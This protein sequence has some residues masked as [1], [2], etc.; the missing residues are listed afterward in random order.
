M[1]ILT[2]ILSISFFIIIII[3]AIKYNNFRA[4][5]SI[6]QKELE[7]YKEEKNYL[8]EKLKEAIEQNNN[9]EVKLGRNKKKLKKIIGEKEN[10][11]SELNEGRDEIDR[12][13]I[14]NDKYENTVIDNEYL[15][16]DIDN[17]KGKIEHLQFILDLF[18]VKDLQ[19]NYEYN[20]EYEIKKS[21][22]DAFNKLEKIFDEKLSDF[23][24]EN[25]KKLDKIRNKI[26][27]YIKFPILYEKNSIAVIGGFSSGKSQF[28][29]S[30]TGSS[31]EMSIDMNVCTAIPTYISKNKEDRILAYTQSYNS[32]E[33]SYEL[34]QGFTNIELKKDSKFN[35]KDIV[36]FISVETDLPDKYKNICFIDSPGFHSADDNSGHIGAEDDQ[37]ALDVIEKS[38][39]LI[40]LISAEKGSLTESDEKIIE[41]LLKNK[42]I[43]F[44][45]N[46]ADDKPSSEIE[47]ILNKI[48]EDLEDIEDDLDIVGVC[49]YSSIYDNYSSKYFKKELDD[50][51]NDCNE[52][53]KDN[54]FIAEIEK[55]F[56]IEEDS[57]NDSKRVFEDFIDILHK[58]SY[59]LKEEDEE[60]ALKKIK[61][62]KKKIKKVDDTINDNKFILKEIIRLV[63]KIYPEK[64]S[65]LYYEDVIVRNLKDIHTEISKL[66]MFVKN[67]DFLENGEIY[68]QSINYIESKFKEIDN[69]KESLDIDSDLF[70][71]I[72]CE[73]DVFK[74]LL[75]QR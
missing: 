53:I 18:T 17:K 74:E 11:E 40:Y 68:F 19:E 31:I 60:V 67:K 33:I 20:Y 56:N 23:E 42:K 45:V 12:A 71:K 8:E 39:Y 36:P 22:I 15:K 50:F 41:N 32:K 3:L 26:K 35:L 66:E 51:F 30:L 1:L 7:K 49:S 59:G 43:Y 69:G 10:L 28:L 4:D 46:K 65:E 55:V 70:N 5:K 6:L 24:L 62:Y 25:I 16:K 13:K 21:K 2:L 27:E 37:R 58:S 52:A 61:Y 9:L 38:D 72:S 73:K 57:L 64:N 14:R 54:P 29:N 63:N 75:N 44:V 34:Y 47:E 48:I